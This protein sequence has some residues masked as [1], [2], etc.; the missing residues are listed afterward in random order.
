MLT[1]AARSQLLALRLCAA[2]LPAAGPDGRR[3]RFAD[4]NP[5]FLADLTR[6]ATALWWRRAKVLVR[7]LESVP[8]RKTFNFEYILV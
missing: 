7:F 5:A 1:A 3:E 4:P 6:L 8:P 2:L